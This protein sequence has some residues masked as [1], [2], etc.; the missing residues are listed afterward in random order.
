MDKFSI[1]FYLL[2]SI[3]TAISNIAFG[4]NTSQSSTYEKHFSEKA[5]DGEKKGSLG[6]SYGFANCMHTQSE[7]G[8][9]WSVKFGGDAVVY[10]ITIYS[11]TDVRFERVSGL[12][13]KLGNT[14]G[15][16]ANTRIWTTPTFSSTKT[17]IPKN[18]VNQL[19]PN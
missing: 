11:R 15:P 10:S 12:H 13:V 3:Q 4:E 5:V 9:W 16:N 7:Q 19:S 17:N 8:P 14:D 18:L 2:W 6:K 1:Y